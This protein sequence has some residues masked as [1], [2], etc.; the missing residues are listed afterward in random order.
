MFAP[1][2]GTRLS[3]I[4]GDII[5]LYRQRLDLI[6]IGHFACSPLR[7]LRPSFCSHFHPLC[8]INFRGCFSG[9]PLV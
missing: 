5:L 8:C 3:G 9:S 6:R 7:V 2:T 4:P 1:F